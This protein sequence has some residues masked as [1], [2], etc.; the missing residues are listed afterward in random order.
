MTD[1]TTPD[2]SSPMGRGLVRAVVG[3]SAVVLLLA[4]PDGARAGTE[5]IATGNG[6][7]V[8]KMRTSGR[9]T[10][11][12]LVDDATQTNGFLN[13]AR[14]TIAGTASMD[15]A[16]A[17][18]SPSNPDIVILV[19]GAGE[20]PGSAFTVERTT[21]RL[22]VVTPFPTIRC[23]VSLE[24]GA[25]ECAASHPVAFD[26][27]WA[28]SGFGSEWRQEVSRNVFGP[29]TIHAQGQFELQQAKA[30]GVWAGFAS[31]GLAASLLDSKGSTVTREVTVS[32][33]P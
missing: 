17:T 18:P 13:V 20:I 26:L 4:P 32:A 29:V 25:F 16:W 10:F 8:T 19:Q 14:D 11:T 28:R 22:N 1:A 2:E 30:N 9:S 12:L 15:F 27:R 33:R 24:S 5:T 6:D 23:E 31:Q 7:R 3:V 21:A